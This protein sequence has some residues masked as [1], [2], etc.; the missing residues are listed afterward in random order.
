MYNLYFVIHESEYDSLPLK[1][2]KEANSSLGH[3]IHQ[4]SADPRNGGNDW[5]FVFAMH[6]VSSST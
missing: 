4:P 2:A 6:T 1:I 3:G 5:L